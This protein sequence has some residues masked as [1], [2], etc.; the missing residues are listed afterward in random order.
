MSA[1]R[2]GHRQDSQQKQ[3][4]DA[5]SGID[6]FFRVI[7]AVIDSHQH[8]HRDN[9]EKCP[10]RLPAEERIGRAEARLSHDR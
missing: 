5:E 1:M 3:Q 6:E 7:A 8:H 9:T 2:A 4:S 10:E